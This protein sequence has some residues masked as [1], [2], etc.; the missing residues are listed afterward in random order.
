[1][2]SKNSA[3]VVA[4]HLAKITNL[5]CSVGEKKKE[6]ERGGREGGR[7]VGGRERERG[8]ERKRIKFFLH[9]IIP[10]RVIKLQ[11]LHSLW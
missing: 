6:R 5:F 8:R 1:M 3:I 7:E 11:P 10:H 9:C 4:K 2:H